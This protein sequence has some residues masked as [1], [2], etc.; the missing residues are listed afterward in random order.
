MSQIIQD[1]AGPEA[2]VLQSMFHDSRKHGATN[3]GRKKLNMQHLLNMPISTSS[4]TYNQVNGN[5]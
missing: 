4:D 3:E 5:R 2:F 1:G